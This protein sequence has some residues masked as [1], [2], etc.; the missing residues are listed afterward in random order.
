MDKNSC[1]IH[2]QI[3]QGLRKQIKNLVYIADEVYIQKTKWTTPIL[4]WQNTDDI[5][6]NIYIENDHIILYMKF[7]LKHHEEDLTGPE[8]H[9]RYRYL[10][11]DPNSLDQLLS[12][13]K[14]ES[15]CQYVEKVIN[16]NGH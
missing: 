10:L 2:F 3:L 7:I 6:F 12:L 9:E 13:V 11:S 1:K 15:D 16:D 5:V 4:W 14:S 8:H